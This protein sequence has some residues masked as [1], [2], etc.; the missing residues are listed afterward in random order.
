M[1]IASSLLSCVLFGAPALP[2]NSAIV[3]EPEPVAQGELLSKE[4]HVEYS[5]PRTNWASANVGQK[6]AVQD[7]LRTL[8]LSRATLRLAELGRL[9]VN[10]LTTLEILPPTTA[11]SKAILDL[12]AGAMYFFTREKPREFLI[13]TPYAIGASRGTEFLTEVDNTGRTVLTVF[14]GEVEL[15]NPLGTLVLTNGEQGTVQA[16]RPPVKTAAIQATKIV[17]WW[18]YYPGV[19]DSD[20]LALTS[21]ERVA[22]ATSLQAYKEGDLKKALDGY[23]KGRE[24][25]GEPERVYYAGLLLSVGQVDK[26]EALLASTNEPSPQAIALRQVIAVVSSRQLPE[27]PPPK[28]ATEW[29]ALSYVQQPTNLAAALQ[30]ARRAVAAD[31]GFGFAWERMAELE[32]SFGHVPAAKEALERSLRLAPRNAQALALRGFILSAENYIGPAFD[33]FEQAIRADPALGNGWLG[34]GLCRIRTG[35]DEGGLSDLQTAAALEPDRSLLRSYLGKAFGNVHDERHAEKELALAQRLDPNDPTPWLYAAL[36]HQQENRMNEGVQDLEQSRALNDNR[37]VYRSKLLLDEDRAVRSAS[38]ATI[39]DRVGMEEVAVREAA[40]AV[41]SDYGNY[42]SHLF[43]ANSLDALRDPTLFNLRYEAAWAHE[44]LLASLLAP[45]GAGTLSQS[46]SQQEYSKLFEANG[47]GFV[48]DGSW[49]S[50]GQF[51]QSASQFGTFGDTS[52]SIDAHYRHHDGVRP[53]NTLT[54]RAETTTLKQQLTPQDSVLLSAS[55]ADYRSGDNFQ[56]YDPATESRPDFKY[57]QQQTPTLVVG[58]H[59]EWAPGVHTLFLGTH[60]NADQQFSDKSVGRGLLFRFAGTNFFQG[61]PVD[62]DYRNRLNLYGGELNQIVQGERQILVVGGRFQSGE[63]QAQDRLLATNS[64]LAMLLAPP[65]HQ[66]SE[67]FERIVGYGYYTVELPDDLWLTGGF[68]YDR[69]TYPRNF[70]DTP[71]SPGQTR[72]TDLGAKGALIWNPVPELTIRGAYSR[73]LGGV[74]IDQDYSLEPVQLAGFDQS[75]RNIMPVA[76]TGF[77]SAPTFELIGAA[78]D[79]RFRTRTYMEVEGQSLESHMDKSIGVY[80]STS[81]GTFP[82]VSTL[83]RFDYR[84]RSLLVTINQLV[85]NDWSL[86]VQY[87]FTHSDFKTQFPEIPPPASLP[88]N[89][90]VRADLHQVTPYVVFNHHSGLFAR[91]EAPWYSQ[92]NY[93]YTP[94]LP[95]DDFYQVNL[96]AGYRFPHQFG[97]VTIGLLNVTGTDYHLNPL[98]LYAELPRERVWSVRLRLSF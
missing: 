60:L 43:L 14:D 90:S 53:N 28:L 7:R 79:L 77:V 19:L 13:Q 41:S 8:A 62:L 64:G 80:Q 18:L 66:V 61:V 57:A 30:S 33:A 12:K 11:S 22:L 3:P 54:F 76:E 83:K 51:D 95:G 55:V 42:S 9:R 68:A 27:D 47:F 67:G 70:Q 2:A 72:R 93:G 73:S 31:E 32:F 78:M 88:P 21:D 46:I 25:A 92:R 97:D 82:A 94:A 37:R 35:D 91:A 65:D 85:R 26:A 16:G 86:G 75:F 69:I 44:L 36:L 20:E 74:S 34:R 40:R 23:P 17:Q 98:N 50:D 87:R 49:R 29:L 48:S 45:V 63:F 4:G 52:Y 81:S 5:S 89:L 56:Y 59:H 71:V 1:R 24:P 39:Y 10:E 6:L 58:Y 96:F 15:S 38:L 84:E